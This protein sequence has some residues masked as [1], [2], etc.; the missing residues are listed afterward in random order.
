MREQTISFSTLDKSIYRGDFHKHEYLKEKLYREECVLQSLEAASDREHR[1]TIEEIKKNGDDSDKVGYFL[2]LF[3]EKLLVRKCAKN[4]SKAFPIRSIDRERAIRE[5]ASCLRWGPHQSVY[6]VDIK[7][8]YESINHL[9]LIN[10]IKESGRLSGL[11]K[12]ILIRILNQYWNAGG[13]GLPRGLEI[14]NPLA[15]AY[16][17]EVDE[18]ISKQEHCLFYCRFV[19]DIIIVSSGLPEDNVYKQFKKSMPGRLKLNTSKTLVLDKKHTKIEFPFLGYSIE[20]DGA[21]NQDTKK[22]RSVSLHI[23]DS[24]LKK[25]KSRIYKSFEKY[26]V[27][28]DFELL[29]DRLTFLSSN[30][31]NKRGKGKY[32]SGIFYSNRQVDSSKSIKSIDKYIYALIKND[33]VGPIQGRLVLS[34]NEK[35]KILSINFENRF[36]TKFHY[37]YNYHRSKEIVKVWE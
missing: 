14:A 4:I 24:R 35:Q 26:L 19:D 25:I 30:R 17:Y 6:R 22:F 12:D 20:V 16:L 9:D 29:T 15:N 2:P 10:F 13:T 23:S 33:G 21:S 31:T 27:E 36:N 8:F 28:K 5:L 32:K 1:F 18:I 34:N 11:T 3:Y 7:S 37:K